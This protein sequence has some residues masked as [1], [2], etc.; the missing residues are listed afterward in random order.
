VDSEFGAEF[1]FSFMASAALFALLRLSTG[2]FGRPGGATLYG[3]W[4][5]CRSPAV[6]P[7]S[8]S[9]MPGDV[10][11]ILIVFFPPRR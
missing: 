7:V 9:L 4:P 5:S 6:L 1:G 11:G 2:K 8:R 10:V 3:S